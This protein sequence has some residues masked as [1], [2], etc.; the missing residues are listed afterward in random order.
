MSFSCN[1]TC[2]S[3]VTLAALVVVAGCRFKA[4]ST[5]EGRH[6]A[7]QKVFAGAV[8]AWVNQTQEKRPTFAVK[9]GLVPQSYTVPTAVASSNRLGP[10]GFTEEQGEGAERT[11]EGTRLGRAEQVERNDD[12]PLDRIEQLCPGLEASVSDALRTVN[13]PSRIEKYERLTRGCPASADLWLWLGKDYEAE[14]R[15]VEANRSFENVLV[16]D[17]GNEAAEALL[18]LVRQRLNEGARD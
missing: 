17:P 9:S 13:T 16:H 15:L 3:F 11:E 12:S 6:L 1:R 10:D 7:D 14:G 5:A 18:A 4:P 2:L 8:P